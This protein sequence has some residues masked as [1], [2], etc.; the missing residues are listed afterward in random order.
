[1]EEYNSWGKYPFRSNGVWWIIVGAALALSLTLSPNPAQAQAG[2]RASP[3]GDETMVQG[4]ME[5]EYAKSLGVSETPSLKVN[6]PRDGGFVVAS[7][8]PV[9]PVERQPRFTSPLPI[10]SSPSPPPDSRSKPDN[11]T[12]RTLTQARSYLGTPYRRG[13]SLQ[14]GRSTDCSGFVQFIYKKANI[15]L[16]RSSSEQAQ[17]GMKVT[18]SLDF[19]LMRPGDLLFFGHRGRHIGH[20]GIY[21]GDGKMIHASSHRR[22]VIITDLRQSS[23]EGA[24]V[25]AKRLFEL[26]YPQIVSI[27]KPL[28]IPPFGH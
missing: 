9:R 15:D 25:V 21:L 23:Y 19:A 5:K 18:H 12:E 28:P 24:F 20:A 22:G 11:L 27:R 2:S 7:L 8:N 1:M 14:T 4:W 10:I 16:P 26:Q 17:V 13:G 3:C 6:A